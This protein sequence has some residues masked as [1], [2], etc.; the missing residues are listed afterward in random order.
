[1]YNVYNY[2]NVYY[3]WDNFKQTEYLI[4]NK[5]DFTFTRAK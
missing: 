1:M 4:G 2:S 5:R 3:L